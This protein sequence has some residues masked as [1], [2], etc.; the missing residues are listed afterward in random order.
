LAASRDAPY[1]I[2]RG[3]AFVAVGVLGLLVILPDG[4]NLA[5]ATMWPGALSGVLMYR[6]AAHAPVLADQSS[7]VRSRSA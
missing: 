1:M 7:K 2:I 3:R 5:R 4:F 6:R